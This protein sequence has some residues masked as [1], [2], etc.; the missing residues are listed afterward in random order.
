M[1]HLRGERCDVLVRHAR[2]EH[3]AQVHDGFLARL[4]VC[5]GFLAFQHV[6][7]VLQR[8]I[9]VVPRPNGDRPDIVARHVG[10][11]RQ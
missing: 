1:A 2:L 3:P 5:L 7:G 4:P 6:A 9:H 11:E 8:R 10:P